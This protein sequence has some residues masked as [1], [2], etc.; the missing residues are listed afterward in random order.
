MISSGLMSRVWPGAWFGRAGSVLPVYL[1]FVAQNRVQKRAMNLDLSIVADEA[2]LA[3]LVHE[4]A[5]P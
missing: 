3:E 1:G 5:N 2:E 4:E